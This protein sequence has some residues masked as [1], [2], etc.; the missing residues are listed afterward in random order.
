[1]DQGRVNAGVARDATQGGL[2]AVAGEGGA[3]CRQDGLARVRASRRPPP[4][5]AH[6]SLVS[7]MVRACLQATPLGSNSTTRHARILFDKMRRQGV[8]RML[9]RITVHP[10]VTRRHPDIQVADVESAWRSAIA[11]RRRNYDPPE[12]YAAAGAD[13]HGRL[14]EMVGV[15]LDDG[16]LLIFHAMRLT[17]KMAQELQ[18]RRENT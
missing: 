16:S 18:V 7:L 17:Y 3:G 4:P 6:R 8:V 2:V 9:D 11:V 1:M 15:E 5:R 12:Y 10:R 14:L 13:S